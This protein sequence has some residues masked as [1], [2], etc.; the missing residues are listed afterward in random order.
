MYQLE[1]QNSITMFLELSSFVCAG[2]SSFSKYILIKKLLPYT[3]T[4]FLFSL[5]ITNNSSCTSTFS[6]KNGGCLICLSFKN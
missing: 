4:Q 5:A 6:T 1:A 3:H 2:F